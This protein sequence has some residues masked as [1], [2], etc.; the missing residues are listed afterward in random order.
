MK[1]TPI[2]NASRIIVRG[3]DL[4]RCCRCLAPV[5]AGAGHW[6]HRRSRSVR[7]EHQHAP[8]NGVWLCATCHTWVHGHPFEARRVG[9]IVSRYSI[10]C[11]TPVFT[12]QHGW[13]LLS[14]DGP[15]VPTEPPEEVQ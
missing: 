9:F 1:A 7:D 13:V 2:P 14:H 12:R 11:E 10:P 6:H 4:H 15:A 5:P 8:C 3:R